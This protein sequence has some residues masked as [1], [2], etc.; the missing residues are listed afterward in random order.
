MNIKEIAAANDTDPM[1]IFEALHDIAT[2]N[3]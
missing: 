3:C 2:S 1:G